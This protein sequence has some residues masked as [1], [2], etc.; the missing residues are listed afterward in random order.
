MDGNVASR[1]KVSQTVIC[2]GASD[3][4]LPSKSDDG[5]HDAHENIQKP[6]HEE[7]V[8]KGACETANEQECDDSP[9]SEHG[10]LVAHRAVFT[11]GQ[12]ATH[13]RSFIDSEFEKDCSEEHGNQHHSRYRK[14]D[15]QDC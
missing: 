6:S 10:F 3:F 13:R 9:T 5:F 4:L 1:L 11:L 8:T 7:Q 15:D 12:N 2:A 14:R